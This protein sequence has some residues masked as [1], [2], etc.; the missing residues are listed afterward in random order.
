MMPLK[1]ML[2]IIL[3]GFGSGFGVADIFWGNHLLTSIIFTPILL[4][5]CIYYVIIYDFVR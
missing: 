3:T 2:C 5:M 1:R 4:I